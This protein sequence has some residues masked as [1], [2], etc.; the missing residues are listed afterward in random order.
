MIHIKIKTFPNFFYFD[1]NV[2]LF[3]LKIYKFWFNVK[4]YFEFLHRQVWVANTAYIKW[5]WAEY[6]TDMIVMKLNSG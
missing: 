2:F 1:E 4:M 6:K 3:Q 5:L